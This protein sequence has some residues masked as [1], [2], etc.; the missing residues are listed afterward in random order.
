[1][2]DPDDEKH[3][4]RILNSFTFRNHVMIVFEMLSI[5]LYEVIKS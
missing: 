1:M 5:N 3:I 2:N 4:V